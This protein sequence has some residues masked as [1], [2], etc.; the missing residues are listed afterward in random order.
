MQGYLETILESFIQHF[1]FKDEERLYS[2]GFTFF[3]PCIILCPIDD[4]MQGMSDRVFLDHT[5]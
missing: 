3:P 4:D 5:L 1:H 2:W